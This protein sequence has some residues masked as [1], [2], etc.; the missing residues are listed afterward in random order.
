[1]D[2]AASQQAPRAWP[3]YCVCAGVLAYALG[4]DVGRTWTYAIS[5]L[6]PIREAMM[7]VMRMMMKMAV[8]MRVLG[9]PGFSPG[10]DLRR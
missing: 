10:H 2:T 1:M 8:E 5:S 4:L 9:R 6:L 7:M 3:A